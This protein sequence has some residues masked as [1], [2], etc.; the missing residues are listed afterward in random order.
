MLRWSINE[1]H[2]I[3]ISVTFTA[4]YLDSKSALMKKYIV[5]SNSTLEI[6]YDSEKRPL[7]SSYYF[8][9]PL[10]VKEV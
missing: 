3:K 5:R 10:H 1:A 4:P 8:L 7:K 2:R 9:Y 6:Q